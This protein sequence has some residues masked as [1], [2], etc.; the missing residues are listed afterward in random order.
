MSLTY[1]RNDC[2]NEK[3]VGTNRDIGFPTKQKTLRNGGLRNNPISGE[4]RAFRN[5]GLV[6]EYGL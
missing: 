5:K 6:K 2:G 3:P 4:K 1:P